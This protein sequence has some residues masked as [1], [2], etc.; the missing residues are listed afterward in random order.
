MKK[1]VLTLVS[2]LM[3]SVMFGQTNKRTSAFNYHRY[4]KLDLAK[5]AIDEAAQHEKTIMD[6]RTWF[7]RGNIYY[8]IAV[9]FDENY[10]N[11]DP[12]PLGVALDSYKKAKELDTKGE[13]TADI[14]KYTLAIGEGYYNQGVI[15]YNNQDFKGAALSFEKSFNVSM[16][17]GRT[18]TS[19][20]YN[21]A[22]AAILGQET[23]MAICYYERVLGMEYYRPD[24]YA[25]LAD[26]YKSDGDTALS[27]ATVTKGREMFPEDF[28]LL[29]AETNIFLTTN[30]QEKAKSNLE[31]ALKIDS[32][33][34]S[35]F[36]AVGTIYD[37]MYTE[38]LKSFSAI[39]TGMMT[40]DLIEIIGEPKERITEIDEKIEKWF[41]N[42]LVLSIENGK[43]SKI[44]LEGID[45]L[46]IKAEE[47]YLEAIELS[48]D[49]IRIGLA[50]NEAEAIVGKPISINRTTNEYGI[51][52]QWVYDDFYLYFDNDKLTSWQEINTTS[53]SSSTRFMANYN[54]G[55]LYVNQAADILEKA[56]DLPLSATREYEE[57]KE[58][59]DNMLKKS[60]PY[61]ER[62]L[63]LLPDDV[64]TMVSL[65]EI[66]TRLGM[67]EKLAEIDKMLHKE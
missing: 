35:I 9:S 59:A 64:N 66:Y 17:V 60:T 41:Y 47:S 50:S 42:N 37:Q 40:K 16:E 2:V 29:I 62:A 23:E 3:V 28:N 13:Y 10:R 54:L 45:S 15:D 21:A 5:E 24:I 7:Y 1:T 55:A 4:G 57:M 8:D 65:K 63:E 58:K 43:V 12:D 11:L 22:I 33:N 52:E 31:E 48:P 14:E 51:F 6:A 53:K 46:L 19:A 49:E 26:L 18:D 36:F 25:S 39:K 61:L 30:E 67:L 32:S 44:N 56:N 27:L 20:L 34:P 38:A